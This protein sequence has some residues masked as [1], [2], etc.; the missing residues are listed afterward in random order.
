VDTRVSFPPMV[1]STLPVA[2]EARGGSRATPPPICM[3]VVKA[4]SP[5]SYCQA[6]DLDRSNRAGPTA[7]DKP[8]AG[9]MKV[10]FTAAD[11]V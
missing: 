10:P 2:L 6:K 11:R 3:C 5:A 7:T 1:A 8:K 4:L 9:T